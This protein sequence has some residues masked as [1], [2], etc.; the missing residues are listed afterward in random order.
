MVSTRSEAGYGL[1]Y[2]PLEPAVLALLAIVAAAVA[3]PPPTELSAA[4]A[5]FNRHAAFA[6]PALSASQLDELS[7]GDVVRILERRDDGDVRAIGLKVVRADQRDVWVAAQDTH[8]VATEGLTEL[9]LSKDPATGKAIWYGHLDLPSPFKDRHW[10]VS[11]WNNHALHAA[12]DGQAWEHPWKL[13]RAAVP[14]A[15]AAAAAGRIRGIDAARFDDAILTER[16]R[17][18]WIAIE[19]EGPWALVGYHATTVVGGSI[20]DGLMAR[21]VHLRMRSLLRDLETRATTVVRSHYTPGHEPL[22]AGGPF[23]TPYYE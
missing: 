17:G 18:A 6:L 19:L 7:G 13:A 5:R 20:P 15:R 4:L 11:V 8:Y 1:L 10:V 9:R 21:A 16:N 12:T 23:A 14:D 22:P 2:A 3:A